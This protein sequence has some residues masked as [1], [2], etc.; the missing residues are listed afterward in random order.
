ME[1][2]KGKTSKMGTSYKKLVEI[3]AEHKLNMTEFTTCLILN[4][5][6]DLGENLEEALR[7]SREANNEYQKPLIIDQDG[8]GFK[9]AVVKLCWEKSYAEKMLAFYNNEILAK[10]NP[11]STFKAMMKGWFYKRKM[12]LP[13]SISEWLK[14]YI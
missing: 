12:Y 6:H 1:H 8:F 5:W 13:Q 9:D 2:L 11:K 4:N 10:S 14:L 3:C 7:N